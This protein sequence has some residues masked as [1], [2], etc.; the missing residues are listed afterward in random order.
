MTNRPRSARPIWTTRPAPFTAADARRPPDSLITYR[1]VNFALIR[2]TPQAFVSSFRTFDGG[3]NDWDPAFNKDPRIQ[4]VAVN[5]NVARSCRASLRNGAALRHSF[6]L[7]MERLASIQF[8]ALNS[9]ANPQCYSLHRAGRL[10]QN[11]VPPHTARAN[12]Q[13]PR[14]DRSSNRR[15]TAKRPTTH[16]PPGYR[17]SPV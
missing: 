8:H 3:V 15:S 13:H 14:P 2:T 9:L 5:E 7:R 1:F 11:T 10:P 16:L 4:L 6:P 12:A 17:L